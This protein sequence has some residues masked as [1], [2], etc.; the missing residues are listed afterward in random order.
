MEMNHNTE[1]EK[2]NSDK[3]RWQ[4]QTKVDEEKQ[5]KKVL[6]ESISNCLPIYNNTNLVWPFLLSKIHHK[7]KELRLILPLPVGATSWLQL[8]LVK[9]SIKH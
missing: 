6:S 5:N 7:L 3:R 2:I 4:K 9:T 8:H 1:K